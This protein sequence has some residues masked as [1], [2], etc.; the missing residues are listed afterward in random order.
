MPAPTVHPE[1]RDPAEVAPTNS[2]HP[3]DPVWVGP[4]RRSDA[5]V[6]AGLSCAPCYLRRLSRCPHDHACMR[7]VSAQTVIARIETML[8]A[9]R[10]G[11]GENLAPAGA[12][13]TQPITP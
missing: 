5:V 6:Q 10:G 1:Q 9:R 3:T 8:G 2:Y 11:S 12:P 4:Y 7:E 13:A